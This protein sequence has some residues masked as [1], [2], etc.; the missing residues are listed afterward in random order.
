ME[1]GAKNFLAGRGITGAALES[2][3]DLVTVRDR[4]VHPA[5]NRQQKMPFA[6]ARPRQVNQKGGEPLVVL[7]L[8]TNENAEEDG[9]CPD[10]RRRHRELPPQRCERPD[11]QSQE[12]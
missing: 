2:V 1:P 8:D 6:V 4:A 9:M 12:G 5:G 10:Y 3:G 11:S 7:R